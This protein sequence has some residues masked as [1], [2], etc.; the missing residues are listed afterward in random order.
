[1]NRETGPSPSTKGRIQSPPP[2][3][4]QIDLKGQTHGPLL[5]PLSH[6]AYLA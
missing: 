4:Y 1:M 3:A 6:N 2:I 5:I